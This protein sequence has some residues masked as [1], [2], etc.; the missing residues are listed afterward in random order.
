MHFC[1][2]G[3]NPCIFVPKEVKKNKSLEMQTT[4][5]S[6]LTAITLKRKMETGEIDSTAGDIV[7]RGYIWL[8]ANF[9][10][11]KASIEI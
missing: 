3:S 10:I 6:S 7:V 8:I 5:I 11:S 4:V 9:V 2:L 1:F